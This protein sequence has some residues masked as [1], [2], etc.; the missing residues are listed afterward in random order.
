MY[1]RDFLLNEVHKISQLLARLMG[2]KAEGKYDEY[3]QQFNNDLQNEYDIELEKLLALNEDEFKLHLTDSAYSP[4]KLNAL[5]QMLYVFAEPFG[6][7]GETSRILEKVLIIFD[8]LEQD[9]H[10]QSFENLQKKNFIYK[11]FT[12][13]HE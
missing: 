5:S 4:E 12:A 9:H 10:T 2:L 6:N 7:D 8:M 13:I 11:H 3:K 1:Q